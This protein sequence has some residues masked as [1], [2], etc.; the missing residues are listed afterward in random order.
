MDEAAHKYVPGHNDRCAFVK[1]ESASG[2]RACCDQPPLSPLHT[3]RALTLATWPARRGEPTH[4]PE[5]DAIARRW[6]G[7]IDTVDAVD[8]ALIMCSQAAFAA[9]RR[10]GGQIAWQILQDDASEGGPGQQAR[11]KSAEKI[12]AAIPGSDK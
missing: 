6:R 8:A 12:R 5:A 2:M 1:Y 10:E 7:E 9:G 11:R 3:D 4:S